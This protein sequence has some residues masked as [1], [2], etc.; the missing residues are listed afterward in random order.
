M[1]KIKTDFEMIFS[2]REL[3]VQISCISNLFDKFQSIVFVPVVFFTL[4]IY[5]SISPSP[6]KEDCLILNLHLNVSRSIPRSPDSR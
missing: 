5:F 1:N 6:E 2:T 4:E 3:Q